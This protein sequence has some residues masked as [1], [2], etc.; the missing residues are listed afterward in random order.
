MDYEIKKPPCFDL[1]ATLD[2]GQCF[3][4]TVSEDGEARLFYKDRF[5]RVKQTADRLIF[6][7][8]TADEFENTWKE[9]FD[10]S[11]DYK[12]KIPILMGLIGLIWPIG[13]KIL[14][15]H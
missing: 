1:A 6:Y 9:Y 8:T 3:R 7:N 13:P 5:L 15:Q 10:L 2:C 11:R 12:P 14:Q 4:A